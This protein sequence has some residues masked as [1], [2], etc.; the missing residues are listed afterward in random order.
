MPVDRDSIEYTV[1]SYRSYVGASTTAGYVNETWGYAQSLMM[2]DIAALQ[3]MYGANYASNSSSTTYSWSPTTGQMF[4]NGVGQEVPGGNRILQ[5]VWDGGGTDTYDFSNYT[6]GVKVDLQPAGW[7]TTSA[8]Q[9]AK[10]H[11]NSSKIAAGNIAN[12]L[13]YKGDTRS[14]IE[15]AIGSSGDDTIMGNQT[16]NSLKGGAGDD[17][18]IGG[19]GHDVLDGGIGSDTA[20]YIGLRSN[21]SVTLLSDGSLQIA[22]LRSGTPDGT[23]VVW[24]TEWFQFADRIYSAGE[25][26]PVAVLTLLTTDPTVTTQP[27]AGQTITGT[28]SRDFINTTSTRTSLRPTE[29]NDTISGFGGNDTIYGLGGNTSSMVALELIPFTVPAATIL[30]ASVRPKGF[31]TSSGRAKRAKAVVMRLNSS[32]TCL[33]Q[34]LMRPLVK[35]K[36]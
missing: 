32:Q 13:L 8:A 16:A 24:N 35:L 33:L 9:L 12:A 34:D 23:D 10:L 31:A 7:S 30:S 26:K 19:A 28:S 27:I 2:Y 15:N 4:I 17:K 5:T 1:M 20:T 36:T 29:G 21:Y 22:D 18:L 14:L 3:H 25:I 6:T 11:Y